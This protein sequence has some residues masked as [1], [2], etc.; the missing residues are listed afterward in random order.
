MLTLACVPI[1]HAWL[2]SGNNI[3]KVLQKQATRTLP[4]LTLK[5]EVIQQYL[6]SKT[7]TTGMLTDLAGALLML[8]AFANAP[9]R[10][11]NARLS[12]QA[13]QAGSGC[14]LSD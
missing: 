3:G 11:R 13:V 9:V 2:A 8:V 10:P 4:R 1:V 5:R 7:W 6:Q 12:S 14:T